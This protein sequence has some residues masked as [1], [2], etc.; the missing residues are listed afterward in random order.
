[1]T[2]VST[3]HFPADPHRVYSMLTDDTFQAQVALRAH[4]IRHE[5]TVTGG[6]VV[7]LK[8]LPSPSAIAAFV[9][10]SL[11]ITETVDWE[12]PAVD[13][14]RN[15]TFTVVVDA[16]P[17]SWSGVTSLAADGAGSLLTYSG[18]L[19]VKIPVFGKM[20]QKQAA[21]ALDSMVRVQ[22][23]VAAGYLNAS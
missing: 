8:E 11:V 15:G 18:E 12:S 9:G 16:K 19:S 20:I 7:N 10:S 4:S 5:F 17:L 21:E 6:H 3:V 23:E 22:E 14:A 1:M 2:L 13:G